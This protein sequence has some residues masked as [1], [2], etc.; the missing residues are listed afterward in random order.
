MVDC[1]ERKTFILY[2]SHYDFVLPLSV[3]QRGDLLTAIFAHERGEPLP[4][5]D[6]ETNMAFIAIRQD[7]VRNAESYT[8]KCEINR[9]NGKKGGRPKKDEETERFSE[10]PNGFSENPTKP[11]KTLYKNKNKNKNKNEKKKDSIMNISFS[12]PSVEEVAVYCKEHGYTIDAQMFVDFY[13]A[14]GWM[15]GKNKMKDW[16]AAVR[17]WERNKTRSTNAVGP[18]GVKLLAEDQY[19]HDLDAIFT[20][21]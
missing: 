3:N 4:K 17:T 2:H 12:A 9:K 1:K 5:L 19:D 20:G 10:K 14:K 7:L 16:K 11:N 18:N 21:G 8:R 6:K 13:T 15:V